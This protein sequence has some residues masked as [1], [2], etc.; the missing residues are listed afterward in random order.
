MS[1]PPVRYRFADLELDSGQRRLSRGTAAVPLGNLTYE[2][3]LALVEAAPNVVSHDRIVEAV[4]NGR[5]TSPETVTQRVKLLRDALGDDAD[6]PRYLRVLR[7]QGYQLIPAVEKLAP[8]DRRATLPAEAEFHARAEPTRALRRVWFPG[9]L[10]VSAVAAVAV[11]ATLLSHDA[12]PPAA[13]ISLA[14]LPL[15]NLSGDANQQYFA[16]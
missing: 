10:V 14:V 6:N 1:V 9:L 5:S 12:S 2:L 11:A 13:P 4:W 8:A 3:L 7:N 15:E 16:D